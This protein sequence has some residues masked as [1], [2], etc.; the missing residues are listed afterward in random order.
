MSS[1]CLRFRDDD[2]DACEAECISPLERGGSSLGGGCLRC[3]DGG[4]EGVDTVP[5]RDHGDAEWL[6]FEEDDAD[7]TLK[8][9]FADGAWI[10]MPE[11]RDVLAI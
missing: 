10:G 3:V 6:A 1:R 8:T 4:R 5:H 9:W 7:D 11:P 2:D